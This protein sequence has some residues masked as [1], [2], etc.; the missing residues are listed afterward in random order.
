MSKEYTDA[1]KTLSHNDTHFRLAAEANALSAQHA[2]IPCGGVS[3]N[4]EEYLRL[5][6]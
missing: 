4:E 2:I 5:F 6:L 3:N 1:R